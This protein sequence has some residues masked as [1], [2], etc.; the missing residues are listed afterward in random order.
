[1]L[2][3]FR[4]VAAAV[5]EK[6][7]PGLVEMIPGGKFSYDVAEAAWKKYRERK[8]DADARAEVQ[9][10][11]A[12]TFDEAR[13]AAVDAVRE[14]V[15]GKAGVS[16]LDKLT[17]EFYLTQI[18]ATVRRTL[19]RSDAPTVPATFSLNSAD[20]FAE[21]IPA[22]PPR[23]APGQPLPGKP[24]WVL[25]EPLG[26]GGFGEVWLAR[27]ARMASLSGAVKFCHGDAARDLQHESGLIDRVM[28][29]GKHPNIVPLLDV[30]L[31]GDTPWVMF[32]YV[33]GGDLSDLIREG[34]ALPREQRLDR[35]LTAL[36]ELAAAVGHFH[37]LTPAVVHRDLKPSNILRDR[38]TDKLRI[39]D[40]G[41]G[42]T[43]ATHRKSGSGRRR[44]IC[45]KRTHGSG[46]KRR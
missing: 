18:P 16:D 27:H 7:L 4:C 15:E 37:R 42:A 2:G 14:A 12:A 19:K 25:V 39:T 8:K 11:A 28:A 32:E 44:R 22:R 26:V 3:F 36:G 13:R 6:G 31:D 33:H 29:A 5:V 21:L 38:G 17:L 30:N 24:G 1:M 41:I 9:Q 46:P 35:T 43:A 20:D 40:F 23:F 34:Q 45:G 10:L